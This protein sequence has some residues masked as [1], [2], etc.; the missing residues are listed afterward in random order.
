[1]DLHFFCIL[2]DVDFE[3]E[4]R[5]VRR[6]VGDSPGRSIDIRIDKETYPGVRR[7][8]IFQSKSRSIGVISGLR[9]IS[10]WF[11][12]CDYIVLSYLFIC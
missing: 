4:R 3:M 12:D 11:V 8:H 2:A 1:M 9:F 7:I 6:M 5:M 10:P